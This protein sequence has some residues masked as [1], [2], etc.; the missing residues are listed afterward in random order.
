MAVTASATR[1]KSD[2]D[3]AEWLPQ[4]GQCRYSRQWVAVKTRWGLTVDS[5]EKRALTTGA[6]H[7]PDV[8]ITV[9]LVG[10]TSGTTP[11]TTTSASSGGSSALRPST[12]T[13]L[14]FA[15]WYQAVDA[16]YGPYIQGRP[17]PE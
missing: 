16:G 6:R 8:T 10:T 13:G 3:P 5:A 15:Y 4:L 17:D 11:A 9:R 7:C 12:G 14:R 1:S 2:Q